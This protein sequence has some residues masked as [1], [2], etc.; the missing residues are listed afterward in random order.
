MSGCP[1]G[2][3]WSGFAEISIIVG[4][5]SSCPSYQVESTNLTFYLSGTIT[6]EYLLSPTHRDLEHDNVIP[7]L[8]RNYHPS[9]PLQVSSLLSHPST[10][11]MASYLTASEAFAREKLAPASDASTPQSA[12]ANKYRGVRPSPTPRTTPPFHLLIPQCQSLLHPPANKVHV[13]NQ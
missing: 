3:A 11:T 13:K 9:S 12:W 8:P 10:P 6:A 1:P 7:R 2:I 5:H 4:Q